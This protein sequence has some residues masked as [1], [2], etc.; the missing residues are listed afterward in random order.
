[1]VLSVPMAP[2]TFNVKPSGTITG[3]KVNVELLK[4]EL[5]GQNADGAIT[6]ISPGYSNAAIS[7]FKF[8]R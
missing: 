2:D 3:N 7:S 6:N 1:M 4:I 8:D 5:S